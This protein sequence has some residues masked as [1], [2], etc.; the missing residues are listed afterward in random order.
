MMSFR[1]LLALS[2]ISVSSRSEFRFPK[3]APVDI[4]H[5][6]STLERVQDDTASMRGAWS[7]HVR[8]RARQSMVQFSIDVGKKGKWEIQEK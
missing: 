8:G 1:A 3:P 7:V 4:K 5:H 2:H 6:D